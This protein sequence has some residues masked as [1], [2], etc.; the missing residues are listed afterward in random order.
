MITTAVTMEL[1]VSLG[2]VGD[3]AKIS[4]LISCLVKYLWLELVHC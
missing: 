3:N 4:R 2:G 1:V